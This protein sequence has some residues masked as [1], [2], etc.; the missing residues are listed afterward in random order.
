VNQAVDDMSEERTRLA[1]ELQQTRIEVEFLQKTKTQL[2]QENVR[3]QSRL[4]TL[5]HQQVSSSNSE[6]FHGLSGF[7]PEKI[8]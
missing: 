4:D 8:I 2:E 1:A 7:L 5:E 3:L 6:P